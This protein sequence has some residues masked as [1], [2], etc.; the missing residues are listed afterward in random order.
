MPKDKTLLRID[1]AWCHM[2]IIV[3]LA[4]ECWL[5]FMDQMTCHICHAPAHRPYCLYFETFTNPWKFNISQ[6][7]TDVSWC[8]KESLGQVWDFHITAHSGSPVCLRGSLFLSHFRQS[9]MSASSS[10]HFP[11]AQPHHVSQTFSPAPLPSFDVL[12]HCC[13]LRWTT[14]YFRSAPGS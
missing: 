2:E 6:V 9:D 3:I 11:S 5:R 12:A 13:S 7:C 8:F 14:D 4:S 1:S 10:A